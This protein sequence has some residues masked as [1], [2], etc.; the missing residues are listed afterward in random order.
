MN[1]QLRLKEF[2]EAVRLARIVCDDQSSGPQHKRLLARCLVSLSQARRKTISFTKRREII[3]EA[4]THFVEA[5]ESQSDA[6]LLLEIARAY[7]LVGELE[8][9]VAYLER[10]NREWPGTLRVLEVLGCVYLDLAKRDAAVSCFVEALSIDAFAPMSNY[11]LA[12]LERHPSEDIA[13]KQLMSISG[14]LNG[15]AAILTHF[16]LA[17]FAENRRDYTAA[18]S[19]FASGNEIK[20]GPNGRGQSKFVDHVHS[21]ISTLTREWFGERHPFGSLSIKPIFV[22]GM[23]RSGTTLIERILTSHSSVGSAGE[24]LELGRVAEALKEESDGDGV[25]NATDI[26]VVSAANDYERNLIA[27]GGNSIRMVDK[28]PLNF[29]HLGVA[30][31]MFPKATIIYCR[32]DPR[33]IA[34]SCFRNNLRWPFCNFEAFTQFYHQFEKLM[35]HWAKCFPSQIHSF[36]YEKFVAS[37]SDSIRRLVGVCGLDWQEDCERFYLN[38]SPIIT[39]SRLQVTKPIYASS[40]GSWRRFDPPVAEKLAGLVVADR[41]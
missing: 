26:D 36:E 10:A 7:E 2:E 32:R 37:P 15:E 13:Y 4:T 31:L 39:P 6:N 11:R 25:I 19:H 38:R 5:L 40:V 12:Q 23:P 3:L 30:H 9:S 28:M 16:A 33:D 17:S 24:A 8:Q 21:S 20:R 41:S 29:M 18:Y 22:V 27:I 14:V 34:V 1:E 35:G